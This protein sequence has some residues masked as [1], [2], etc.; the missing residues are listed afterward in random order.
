M[1]TLA[2]IYIYE[3]SER[4]NALSV[5]TT[6][7]LVSYTYLCH[8]YEYILGRLC[9]FVCVHMCLIF[10]KC[11]YRILWVYIQNTFSECTYRIH[12]RLTHR[13]LP[14]DLYAYIYIHLYI[15]VYRSRIQDV[16]DRTQFLTEH[17]VFLHTFALHTRLARV[18][19]KAF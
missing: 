3:K 10:S 6:Y 15:H 14:F 11:T 8:F 16:F 17:S 9:N 18:S 5:H 13:L 12:P 4:T 1:Y 19:F 2:Y 7:S